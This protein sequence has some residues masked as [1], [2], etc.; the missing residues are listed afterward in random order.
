MQVVAELAVEMD[1]NLEPEP[2]ALGSSSFLESPP[3]A[4]TNG[5]DA[6]LSRLPGT[7]PPELEIQPGPSSNGHNGA[8]PTPPPVPPLLRLPSEAMVTH[9]GAVTDVASHQAQAQ[10]ANSDMVD[11]QVKRPDDAPVASDLPSMSGGT[12]HEERDDKGASGTSIEGEV[13]FDDPTIIDSVVV[14]GE[15]GESGGSESSGDDNDLTV[16]AVSRAS[17]ESAVAVQGAPDE[18]SR[19]ETATVSKVGEPSSEGPEVAAA[20]QTQPPGLG[21]PPVSSVSTRPIT[22]PALQGMMQRYGQGPSG[23]GTGWRK[24]VMAL[25]LVAAIGAAFWL[26]M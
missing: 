9:G 13:L 6:I 19:Q 14:A 11:H 10:I 17:E 8:T 4:I 5:V 24:G 15:R 22:G 12:L 7:L 26:L 1:L 3:G 21:G 23:S 18:E 25:G 20:G 2:S 16:I